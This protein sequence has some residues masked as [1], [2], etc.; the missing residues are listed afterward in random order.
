MIGKLL[1]VAAAT[2]LW[3]APAW[4]ANDEIAA[5]MERERQDLAMSCKDIRFLPDAFW[6]GDINKDGLT[7]VIVQ[8]SAIACDNALGQDCDTLGCAMRIYVQTDD[9]RFRYV[10]QIRGS[11]FSVGYRYGIR[12]IEFR[13]SDSRCRKV[14]AAKCLLITR[15]EG[16][17]LVTLSTE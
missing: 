5:V 10:S 12:I 8:S 6:S 11:G 2:L 16:R 13:I 14:K 4:A 15:V 17:K 1:R 7:D 3:C 9:G